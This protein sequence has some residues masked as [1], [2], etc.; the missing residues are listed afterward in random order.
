MRDLHIDPRRAIGPVDLLLG[1][2]VADIQRSRQALRDLLDSRRPGNTI[3]VLE[4]REESRAALELFV[5]T[6][7]EHQ[8]PVPRRIQ[9]E[10]A[11]VSRLCTHSRAPY[12]NVPPWP[13]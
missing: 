10:L 6:L 8:L 13:E 4:A 1:G 11:L 9:D 5:A 7:V 12:R 3:L 2:L